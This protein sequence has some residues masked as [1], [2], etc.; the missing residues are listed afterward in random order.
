V[1]PASPSVAWK[2][3]EKSDNPV[4]M[5]LSD[6]Y[7]IPAS[8]AWLPGISVPCGFATSED[9]EKELLPVGLQILWAQFNDEKVLEVAHVY[10]QATPWHTKNPSW[11]ED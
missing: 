6:A 2:L 5:Y 7:T 11:F 4:K 9:A 10:E 1:S 3:G 8:L